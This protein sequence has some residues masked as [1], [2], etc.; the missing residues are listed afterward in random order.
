M[1]KKIAHDWDKAKLLFELDKPFSFIEKETGINKG[2]ISKRSKKEGW[3]RGRATAVAQKA[4]EV[5]GYK[6]TLT[7]QQLHFFNEEVI[8]RTEFANSLNL[9]SKKVMK[10]ANELIDSS[11]AGVDFKAICEGVDK[12]SVTVGFN[13]RHAPKTETTINN[14]N[15]QQNDIAVELTPEQLRHEIASRGLPVIDIHD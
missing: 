3:E 8:Q 14:T 15:A 4:S 6:S 2:T 9:F 7:Q 5:E 1:A 10:K 12:H 13:K 11:E